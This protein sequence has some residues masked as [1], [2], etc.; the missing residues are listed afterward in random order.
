MTVPY[1][2]D[3]IR[4]EKEMRG[5]LLQNGS[6]FLWIFIALEAVVFGLLI[7]EYLNGKKMAAMLSAAVCFGL[8][9]DALI[10]AL[11]SAIGTGA[12]LKGISQM[13]F[14]FHG[15]LVPLLL[16]IC[17]YILDAKKTAKRI[18]WIVTLLIMALGLAEGVAT[19]TDPV[20]MAGIIRYASNDATPRW[21]EAVTRVLSF[22]T[23]IPLIGCGI[24]LGIKK[25]NW[26]LM[27]SGIAMFALAALGPATGNFDLI[28][29]ISVPG[30]LL[31]V[32]FIWLCLRK[33]SKGKEA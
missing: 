31:M 14:V 30:E 2:E 21:A 26:H 25:K 32:L 27:I 5:L 23:V 28:F 8:L 9:Y 7:K 17:A 19:K 20:E 22:G 33:Q 6:L 16:P 29:L 18:V 10:M 1:N 3:S 13:R 11:G 4:E 24:A 15:V 12:A